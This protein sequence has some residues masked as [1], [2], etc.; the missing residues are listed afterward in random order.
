[1]IRILL[2]D[3]QA[4]VRQ[5]W[6]MRFALEP[7]IVVVGEA[8]DGREA[9]ALAGALRPDVVLMDV[10]MPVMDGITALEALRGLPVAAIVMTYD[11]AELREGGRKAGARTFI[12]KQEPFETL[13][14]AIRA[15]GERGPWAGRAIQ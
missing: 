5:G 14:A 4:I 2:V 15:S 8:G 3:D 10:E 9:V 1:M 12:G 11:N 13:L 7:D 6:A